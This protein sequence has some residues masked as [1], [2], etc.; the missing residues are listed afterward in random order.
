VT[1]EGPDGFPR[2]N[3]AFRTTPFADRQGLDT[4]AAQQWRI[5]EIT[6]TNAPAYDPNE[7]LKLEWNVA[8]ESGELDTFA[9]TIT[10]PDDVVEAGHTYRVRARVKDTSGRWSHWSQ[11]VQ[12]TATDPD[13][14]SLVNALRITELHYNPV[15]ADTNAGELDV[16][17]D[18]FEF[19]ELMNTGTEVLDL[20][21]V[22]LV[23]VDVAGDNQGIE[24]DFRNSDVTQ[25]APQ[26]RVVVV[27]NQAAFESRYGTGRNVAGQYRGRLSNAGESIHVMYGQ[28]VTIHRFQYDDAHPW[29]GQAD[30]YGSSLVVVDTQGDYNDPANWRGSDTYH[31]TP[32]AAES[33]ADYS[34]VINELLANP[35]A[36]NADMIELHNPTGG[37]VDLRG[38]SLISLREDLH[39]F[40][41]S[42]NTSIPAGGY[43]T[44]DENQLG[45]DLDGVAGG[46][47]W[48]QETDNQGRPQQF[49]QAVSF[50]P[51]DEG[52]SLGRWPTSLDPLMALS[53]LTFGGENARPFVNDV[54]VSEVHYA[55]DVVPARTDP[56]DV[57]FVELYNWT[58]AAVDLSAWRL[59]GDIQM[60]FPAGTTIGPRQSLVAVSFEPSNATLARQFARLYTGESGTSL[61]LWGPFQGHLGDS[62]GA[63]HL[64]RPLDPPAGDPPGTAMWRVDTATYDS[65]L[66]WPPTAAG[67]G[68][69]LNRQHV[70]SLGERASSWTADTPTPGTTQYVVEAPG[71]SNQDGEFDERDITEVLSAGKYETGQ[72]ATYAEGDWDRDGWFSFRDVLLALASGI[73]DQGPYAVRAAPAS[74]AASAVP[75]IGQPL[76]PPPQAVDAVLAQV[77]ASSKGDPIPSEPH[78]PG[79]PCWSEVTEEPMELAEAGQRRFTDPKSR[80]V[81]RAGS[82]GAPP[83][84]HWRQWSDHAVDLALEEDIEVI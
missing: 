6:D 34:L 80:F 53:E 27:E 40:Q 10:I 39:T 63:I 57:E 9:E 17:N 61:P 56:N 41:F 68:D 49:G 32:A 33:P 54:V 46:R 64:R 13:P 75:M 36:P 21:Q 82:A 28:N 16:N 30:G 62:S 18:E 78:T 22:R 37:P 79:M 55:P 65:A 52:I 84:D 44:F 76:D 1:Y 83:A 4:F 60:S 20:T 47:L 77:A 43:L 23:E 73:Y 38:W 26:E 58:N 50:G 51:A 3:L 66:P 25:L 8:W 15:D 81:V 12:F 24:F 11:E 67:D 74:A 5:A 2:H 59:D 72:R 69:S 7:K 42:E 70:A 71:D 19:I 29:P 48:L 45:F 35:V 31:G 14:N